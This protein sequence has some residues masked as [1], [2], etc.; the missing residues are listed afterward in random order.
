MNTK[1]LFSL[2]KLIFSKPDHVW[3][4]MKADNY[5]REEIIKGM[6]FPSILLV[7]I[8]DF[9]GRI[10]LHGFI[11]S[12]V[13]SSVLFLIYSFVFTIAAV[14]I[15]ELL[16][17]YK[18]SIVKDAEYSIAL[19]CFLPL[20]IIL[21]ISGLFPYLGQISFLSLY[22]SFLLWSGL[23]VIAGLSYNQRFSF[24]ILFS[25]IM[26]IVLYFVKYF[27]FLILGWFL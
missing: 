20:W 9:I 24:T 26:I 2:V 16:S 5:T 25:F 7:T 13:Y 21:I 12:I 14:F 3:L 8:A 6:V 22:G 18:S 15:R 1:A 23:G 19:V 10:Q 17:I 4:K 27:T 11:E